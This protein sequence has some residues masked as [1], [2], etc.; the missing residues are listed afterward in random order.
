[1]PKL[2]SLLLLLCLICSATTIHAQADPT[3][4]RDIDVTVFGGATHTYTGLSHG[5]NG[6]VT[7]GVDLNLPAIHT[8]RPSLEVRATSPYDTGK[9]DGQKDILGG[10]R[11]EGAFYR[12]HPYFDFLGGSGKINFVVP[13]TTYSGGH[14]SS[15]P[16]TTVLSPGIGFRFDLSNRFMAFGDVQFQH[17]NTPASLSGHLLAKPFTAGL[18]YRF[19]LT[20]HR[21][22]GIR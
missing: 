1:M 21:V 15:Q 8:I 10:L 2:G 22:E 3:A 12:F 20:R 6:A 9:V 7:G 18:V 11:L 19:T 14:I 13:Y 4:V 17:W 5:G 16:P